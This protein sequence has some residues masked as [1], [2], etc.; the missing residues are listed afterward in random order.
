MGYDYKPHLLLL[1][2]LCLN[3]AYIKY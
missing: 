1:I 2:I 3:V